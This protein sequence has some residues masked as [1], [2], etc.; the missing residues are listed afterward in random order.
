MSHVEMYIRVYQVSPVTGERHEI[1]PLTVVPSAK[2]PEMPLPVAIGFPPC[3]CPQC[4]P[5]RQVG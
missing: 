1:H 5:A 2:D 4:R 3:K